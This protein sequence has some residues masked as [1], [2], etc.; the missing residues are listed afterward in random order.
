MDGTGGDMLRCVSSCRADKIHGLA[1]LTAKREMIEAGCSRM[2][3]LVPVANS[4]IWP[5]HHFE[6]L[7]L[8]LVLVLDLDLDVD[9]D[10]SIRSKLLTTLHIAEPFDA[11]C[12]SCPGP[13][14]GPVQVQ[15]QV[16][17]GSPWCFATVTTLMVFVAKHLVVPRPPN[18]APG[19]GARRGP[20]RGFGPLNTKQALASTMVS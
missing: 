1:R 10:H 4:W 12:I 6:R 5:D 2:L 16:S 13:S 17:D 3:Y 19:P 18:R 20:G 9:L 8:D 11:G 15:V 14:P 7:D